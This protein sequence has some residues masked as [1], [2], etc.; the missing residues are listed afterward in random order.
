MRFNKKAL[1][2]ACTRLE[3]NWSRESASAS[4]RPFHPFRACDLAEYAS[5]TREAAEEEPFRSYEALINYVGEGDFDAVYGTAR[6]LLS[7]I[8]SKPETTCVTKKTVRLH[9]TQLVTGD[10]EIDGDLCNGGILVV[11]G[12]LRVG[13]LYWDRDV[14][15]Q[16]VVLG[17]AEIARTNIY[18]GARIGGDLTVTQALWG[19][20]HS[21][22]I[23]VGGTLHAKLVMLDDKTVRASAAE[24][25]V[26]VA[27]EDRLETMSKKTSRLGRPPSDQEELRRLLL[28][29]LVFGPEEAGE[30]YNCP[31]NVDLLFKRLKAGQPIWRT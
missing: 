8:K 5:T 1:V 4:E 6:V 10:F 13:G 3:G 20:D 14:G 28:P 7:M 21:D 15:C 29:E 25:D 9:S 22:S 31:L 27:D 30:G 11:L 18:G 23:F 2:T 24:I 16:L 12:N 19:I 26:L 17:S